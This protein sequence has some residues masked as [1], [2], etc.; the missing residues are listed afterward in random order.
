MLRI[1]FS[2][3][4]LLKLL[5]A[6]QRERWFLPSYHDL[7]NRLGGTKVQAN[8]NPRPSLQFR[9]RLFA[10]VLDCILLSTREH[11]RRFMPNLSRRSARANPFG[12]ISPGGASAAYGPRT[13]HQRRRK[14]TMETLFHE[15][16]LALRSFA[17]RPAF[18]FVTVATLAIGVGS[19]TTI[20]SVINGVLLT[21]LPYPDSSR[22]VRLGQ[23]SDTPNRLYAMSYPDFAD[24][25]QRNRSFQALAA[26]RGVRLT[27][28]GE[29]EP[30]SFIGAMV[31][32]EFFAALG[33]APAVGRGFSSEENS[34]SAPVVVLSHG[35]WQRRW[36]GDPDLVGSSISL[37]GRPFTVVGIMPP[38]FL[39]PEAIYQRRAELWMP[40]AFVN[41]E[42][43]S[44]RFNGFLQGIGRLRAGVTQQ[45]AQSELEALGAQLKSE[46]PQQKRN[47]T[48]GLAPLLSETVGSIGSTLKP[49]FGAVGLLLVIACVNVANLLLVRSSEREREMALRMAIGASRRRLVRQLLT[50]SLVLGGLG[51]AVGVAIAWGGVGAFIALNPG[52]VPRLK[53]VGVDLQ[54]LGFALMVSLLSSLAFGLAP[55]LRSSRRDLTISLKEGAKSSGASNRQ[56]RLRSGLVVAQTSLALVL[57]VAAGLLIN[58]FVRLQGVEKGFDP[59]NVY[60]LTVSHRSQD[61]DRDSGRPGAPGFYSEVMRRIAS[62]PGVVSVGATAILP[63]SGDYMYQ[64]LAFEGE[65]QVPRGE[66]YSVKYQQVAGDYFQVMGIPLHRGRTFDSGDGPSAPL[67]AVINQSMSR[68]LFGQQSPLGHR[69]TLGERGLRQGVFEIVGVVGDVRTQELS[70]S[71][72]PELYFSIGQTPRQS[73]HIVAR[74]AEADAG[75]LPAMRRQVWSVRSDLPVLHSVRMRDYVSRSIA[76]PR[77]Y[78]LVLGGFAAVALALALVG[79]YSTLAYTVSQRSHE[80]GV[81]MALGASA[82]SVLAMIL[83][84][85]MILVGSGVVLGVGGALLATRALESLVFGIAPTDPLTMAVGAVTVLAGALLASSIPAR[86]ATKLDAIAILRSE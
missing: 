10:I 69:F 32:P 35:L 42:L 9:I 36:G 29:G 83:R 12:E 85:G 82:G 14:A 51:G 2:T 55:A 25:Q 44:Q 34:R 76:S 15:I 30:E 79:I 46:F 37:S 33:V 80:V 19:V 53:E 5:T 54:V 50:E 67:A 20:F 64:S 75:I 16:R 81:R 71:E 1:G 52:D 27:V 70:Q 74:T 62:I 72:V 6:E 48:F 68:E 73:M 43:K 78:T 24:L 17:K 11:F 66:R 40:L 61:S 60:A 47:Y 4:L 49:L 8:P 56:E 39:P 31:S 18:F 77:F 28:L 57:V 23:V 26:S 3:G 59:E 13:V 41:E 58:S 22:I 65:V 7:L 21:P 45:A 84:R 63:L 38:G 86:R